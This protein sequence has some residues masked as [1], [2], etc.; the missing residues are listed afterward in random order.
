MGAG[1]KVTTGRGVLLSENVGNS[2]LGKNMYMFI[3][4]LRVSLYLVVDLYGYLI[5][6]NRKG[7]D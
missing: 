1:E 4:G 3:G 2:G 5:R 6:G 7:C